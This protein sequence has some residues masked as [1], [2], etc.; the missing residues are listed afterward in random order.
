M[1][2]ASFLLRR[3]KVQFWAFGCGG[4]LIACFLIQFL[5]YRLSV[6]AA[7]TPLTASSAKAL[8]VIYEIL[9]CI[10]QYL[11]VIA[12]FL[13]MTVAFTQLYCRGTRFFAI[14]MFFLCLLPYLS[15]Y[16]FSAIAGELTDNIGYITLNFALY[17][18]ADALAVLLA[19]WYVKHTRARVHPST[20]FTYRILPDKHT[21]LLRA[22]ACFTLLWVLSHL[23]L[24]TAL[25]IFFILV[26][27]APETAEETWQ[28]LSP[29]AS[30]LVQAV[31]GYLC[32]V[33]LMLD[34]RHALRSAV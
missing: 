15:A 3:H 19:L 13:A 8:Q 17:Y 7:D 20:V 1:N 23:L 9:G 2:E 6:F 5:M 28:V 4:M 18:F 32:A 14:G 22:I 33:I 26:S 24:Y 34:N 25:T 29:Y 30:L 21:P 31:L 27:G 12:V 16:L 11:K 10:M